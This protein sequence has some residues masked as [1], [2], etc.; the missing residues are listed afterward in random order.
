MRHPIM[1]GSGRHT[2]DGLNQLAATSV[3]KVA[4]YQVPCALRF[5][6]M[7]PKANVSLDE[8][9]KAMMYTFVWHFGCLMAVGGW[10][11]NAVR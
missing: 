5:R 7:T 9:P 2:R 8:H 11:L 1:A 3:A 6:R 4:V 10:T